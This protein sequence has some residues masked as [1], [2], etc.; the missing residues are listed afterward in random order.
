MLKNLLSFFTVAALSASAGA[1][2][3]EINL[4][5][6]SMWGAGTYDGATKT[7]TFGE[8]WGAAALWIGDADYSKF[9]EMVV[10]YE[11]SDNSVSLSVAYAE[12]RKS[13]V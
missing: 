5:N 7:I 4:D 1:A 6:L 9:T 2:T 3:L 12:D 11:K 10:N 13:V 8:E